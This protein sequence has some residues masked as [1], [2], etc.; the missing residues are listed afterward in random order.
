MGMLA[1]AR[2]LG[3]GT[4]TVLESRLLRGQEEP[5]RNVSWF[6]AVVGYSQV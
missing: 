3:I 2:Q 4:G 5:M 6:T 1:I